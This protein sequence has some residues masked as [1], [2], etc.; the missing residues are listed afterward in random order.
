MRQVWRV[1]EISVKAQHNGHTEPTHV[2][3]VAW[4]RRAQRIRGGT[5]HARD[6]VL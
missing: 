3:S 4:I 5:E 2:H 1:I 6:L